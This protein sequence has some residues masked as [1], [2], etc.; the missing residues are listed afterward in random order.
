MDENQFLR[1]T[2]STSY[3]EMIDAFEQFK[4]EMN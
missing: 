1:N 4:N 2:Y 3:K